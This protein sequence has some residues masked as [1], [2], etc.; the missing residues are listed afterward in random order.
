M[1]YLRARYYDTE[2]GRFISEDPLKFLAG[3]N[4]YVY[5]FNNPLNAND[6][7]G[8]YAGIDDL[9]FTAGGAAVGLIAQG[10]ADL[11]RGELSSPQ[12]Y[13]AAGVGGAVA[14][15]TLLYA[16]PVLAGA[17]GSGAANITR[18]SLNY[19][20]GKQNGFDVGSLAFDTTIGAATGLIPGL[21]IPGLTKGRGNF[22]AIYKQLVTKFQN[23]TISSVT[24]QAA[25]KMFVGR[26]TSTSFLPGTITATGAS[27]GYDALWANTGIPQNNFND[28]GDT[29]LNFPSFAGLGSGSS[30]S[31]YPSRSNTNVLQS[32]YCK[33]C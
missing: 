17:A 22:N 10:V 32:V 19:F 8:L 9:I 25:A 31:L 11:F 30:F 12:D 6:P 16:G 18:Q 5:V 15:E 14:G 7:S 21:R 24:P 26:A 2:L 4:H 33:G 1:Y 20:A 29:S 28:F 13:F 27:F 3:I 23:G